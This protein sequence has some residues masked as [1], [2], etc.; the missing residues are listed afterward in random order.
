MK[1]NELQVV[2]ETGSGERRVVGREM[3]NNK[4]GL[5]DRKE[6]WK[7]KNKHRLTAPRT[8]PPVQKPCEMRLQFVNFTPSVTTYSNVRSSKTSQRTNKSSSGTVC[9]LAQRIVRQRVSS[10][11]KTQTEKTN[12]QTT[13]RP[14]VSPGGASRR[15]GTAVPVPSAVLAP[16]A[17]MIGSPR[18]VQ[19]RTNVLFWT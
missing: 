13:F 5:G 9:L 15:G 3:E 19:K 7:F 16:L 12:K 1:K 8:L 4:E 17:P 10:A 6:V 11:G 2:E 18:F 14:S